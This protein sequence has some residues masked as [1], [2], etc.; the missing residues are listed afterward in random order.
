MKKY[1]TGVKTSNIEKKK[2]C[3]II[4]QCHSLAVTGTVRM[5]SVSTVTSRTS[6]S[7]HWSRPCT[8]RSR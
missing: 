4:I 8:G 1:Y 3:F 5:L 7:H 6:H 2:F